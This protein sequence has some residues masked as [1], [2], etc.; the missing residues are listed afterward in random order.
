MLLSWISIVGASA[1]EIQ[2]ILIQSDN[3]A[4][5]KGLTNGLRGNMSEVNS[6]LDDYAILRYEAV[7][8]NPR[9]DRLANIVRIEIVNKDNYGELVERLRQNEDIRWVEPERIISTDC[10]SFDFD[11]PLPNEEEDI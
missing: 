11:D 7:I 1:Q 3:N 5:K 2:S 6:I 9:N 10:S 8:D 4:I